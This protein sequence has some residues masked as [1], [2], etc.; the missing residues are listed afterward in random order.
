VTGDLK[1]EPELVAEFGGTVDC[2]WVD[3]VGGPLGDTC[4][5]LAAVEIIVTDEA[6]NFIIGPAI[7]GD[8][9]CQEIYLFDLVP[10]EARTIYLW[11]HLYQFTEEDFGYNY[12][13]HPD[14]LGIDPA[15]DPIAYDAALMHWIKFNDW[16]SW[17]YM[18]DAVSF[19]MEFD[20]LLMDP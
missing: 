2:T 10:C 17:A 11:F 6:G 20:V 3:G 14:Q 5:M 15:T 12:F 13:L 18:R 1:P 7:L 9:Y 16:P 4:S 8:L 19:S